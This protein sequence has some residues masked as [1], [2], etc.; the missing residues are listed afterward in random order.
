MARDLD[1]STKHIE[2]SS[3]KLSYYFC[4]SLYVFAFLRKYQLGS[5]TIAFHFIMMDAQW[6][7]VKEKPAG[8]VHIF[9]A[10]SWKARAGIRT[11]SRSMIRGPSSFFIHKCAQS[12]CP[13]KGPCGSDWR[14]LAA[15]PYTRFSRG[16]ERSRQPATRTTLPFGL[17]F[18]ATGRT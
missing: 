7:M 13:R 4:R 10:S 17:R 8:G 2:G 15:V 3:P 11:S 18:R 5:D 16:A 1:G 14:G 9:A 6:E 12:T